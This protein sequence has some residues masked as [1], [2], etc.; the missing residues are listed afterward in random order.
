MKK[1]T[2]SRWQQVKTV[3]LVA[4]TVAMLVV[5]TVIV[6]GYWLKWNWTGFNEHIGPNVQQYQPAKTLWDWLQLLTIL[7]IP[8]VV[9]LGTVWFTRQQH[10]TDIQVALDN[11]REEILQ[12]YIDKMAT[13]LLEGKLRD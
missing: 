11:Q 3:W 13:L 8:T 6:L 1:G 10:Q 5:V 4:G 2:R 7:A 12:N 9:G